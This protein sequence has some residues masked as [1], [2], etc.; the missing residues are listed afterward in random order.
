[1]R[2][3]RKRKPKDVPFTVWRTKVLQPR[4]ERRGGELVEGA[5]NSALFRGRSMKAGEQY[6]ADFGDGVR[7]VYRPWSEKNRRMPGF[8]PMDEYQLA[9]KDP[10]KR[11]GDWHHY[12]FDISDEDLERPMKGYG[13]EHRL[14]HGGEPRFFIDRV[15]ENNGAMVSTVEKLRAGIPVGGR[16][17]GADMDTGGA[18]DFLHPRPEAPN[19]HGERRLFE[20]PVPARAFVSDKAFQEVLAK[21]DNRAT[22]GGAPTATS[23]TRCLG[24]GRPRRRAGRRAHVAAAPAAAHDP[25]RVQARS[26][27][28]GCSPSS[29]RGKEEKAP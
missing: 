8:N 15:R 28:E 5:N 10:A 14:T 4:R 21:R 11:A 19:R 9:F 26:S 24:S 20:R 7:A 1:M 13:P 23:G 2:A 3:T 6:E 17:P 22:P 18:T 29:L 25:A 27:S 12:R 16:S